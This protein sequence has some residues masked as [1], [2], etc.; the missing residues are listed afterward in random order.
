[1]CDPA[2]LAATTLIIGA[3]SSIS[4]YVGQA[5]A[6][7]AQVSYQSQL[8]VARNQQIQENAQIANASLRNEYTLE[9]Q[10]QLQD[11]AKASQDIQQESTAALKAKATAQVSVGEA[12]VE[13]LSVDQ[14]MEDFDRQEGQYRD[15]V[16]NNREMS[17]AQ[18]QMNMTAM[19]AQAQGQIASI[20]PYVP[21]PVVQPSFLTPLLQI[22]GSSLETW[23]K[24]TVPETDN[25]GNRTG[26]RVWGW[27]N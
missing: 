7:Q 9:G 4:S 23:D 8:E 20:R 27:S 21:S 1:M 22:G 3:T 12:G 6:A 19:Q 17:A 24:Y 2:T 11:S 14:L 26:R 15:S 13:G 5:Q 25:Q 10:R 18:S 16:T